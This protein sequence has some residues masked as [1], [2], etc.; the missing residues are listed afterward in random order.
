MKKELLNMKIKRALS[1]A[2]AGCLLAGLLTL[3]PAS[4]AYTPFP[5]IPDP[6]QAE[7]AEFLRLMGVV[8]GRPGGIYDPS[9]TLTRAEFCKLAITAMDRAD[10]ESAQRGRTIYLDVGPTHWARGYI[11]LASSISLGSGED[12]KGGTALV[13]GIGDGTFRPD[14]AI[15]YGEAVTILCRVLGFGAADVSSGGAWFDGYL[16]VG[17]RVG[18]T[19]GLALSGNDTITRG[20]AAILFY[21][22]YFAKP[23][24]SKDTYLTQLGGKETET[25]VV[26]DV[27]ATA[28][29]GAAGAFKTTTGTYK[30]D[31]TF[32]ASLEGQEGKLLLDQ[33]GKVLSF[34]SKEGT[35]QRL[36]SI[37]YA[38]ALYFVTADGEE[39][40]VKPA[41]PVYKDGEETTWESAWQELP[42]SKSSA[43]VV[44]AVMHFGADGRLSYIFFPSETVEETEALVARSAP[45]GSNP[46][47]AFGSNAPLFKNGQRVTVSALRQYDVATKDATGT[48]QVSDWKLTGIYENVSPSPA[49]PLK[50]RVLGHDFDVLPSARK[51]LA[52]FAIGDRITLLFT[53]QGQVAGAVS[54]STVK[55]EAVGMVTAVGDG[56]ATVELLRGASADGKAVTV[57]GEFSGDGEKYLN[58]LVTVSSAA[59]GRLSLQLLTGSAG[60]GSL[61]TAA[62]TLGDRAVSAN[63]AVYDRVKGGEL[64]EVEYSQLPASV[65]QS[66]IGF[67]SYDYAGQ[68]DCLVLNDATGD[69]YQ[70]GY[71][72]YETVEYESPSLNPQPGDPKDY[73]YLSNVWVLQGSKDG[74]EVPSDKAQISGSVKQNVP[75]G[76]AFGKN[77]LASSIKGYPGLPLKAVATVTLQS[78][79][80]VGRDAFDVE[81]M[82]VTVAG[83]AWT[84]SKDVQCYNKTT[85]TWY[86]PG[87]EG[88]KAARAWSDDLKLWFD[89]SAAEG[90]K[91][92]LIEVP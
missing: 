50:V 44:S 86:A 60:K 71:F 23:K 48:V 7:C 47:A 21:N 91:I 17:G 87:Q 75:G 56:E 45:N 61:D 52:S 76:I 83:T 9:G 18:L 39:V 26:L 77:E 80:H 79:E 40:D 29:D 84:I 67:V 28:D 5:D 68:V 38:E 2:L 37:R 42:N 8:D 85:K 82:T 27:N 53:A 69:A 59:K 14:R 81:D 46:F 11:N 51:D 92:R 13:S 35:S 1:G 78:L 73:F 62:R 55:A 72:K 57:S 32:D 58:Q 20:Q 63:V 34:R 12:G 90:G 65:P 74:E 41:A 33:D 31:R 43:A 6:V 24:G 16:A 49:S 88:V 89:R 64:V 10:E 19:D 3:S 70:Y 66:K 54:A 30:T 22:L 4:A 15:T 25:G 36:V